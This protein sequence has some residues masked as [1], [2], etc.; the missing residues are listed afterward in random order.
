VDLTYKLD[1]MRNQEIMKTH[2]RSHK[3]E[4]EK[5]KSSSSAI[6]PS[7][8]RFKKEAKVDIKAYQCDNDIV[9][10]NLWLKQLEVYFIIHNIDEEKKKSFSQL[11]LEGHALNWW[12][13]HRKTLRLEGDKPLAKWKVFKILIKSQFYP[14]G[15]V[16]DKCIYWK[17]FRKRKRKSVQEYTTKFIKMIIMMDISPKN[18]D[19]LL[20]Y[21]GGL[22]NHL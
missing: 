21:L 20:K 11:K 14:I 12:E 8:Y 7:Q 15:Y 17:H 3:K 22:Q 16:E 10:L 4:P 5:G 2:K 18:I 19:I 9:K 6:T 13:I 1:W